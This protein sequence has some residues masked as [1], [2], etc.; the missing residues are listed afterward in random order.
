MFRLFTIYWAEPHPER[1]AELDLVLK[2]NLSM[3]Q[4]VTILSQ[5]VARPDWFP[6]HPWHQWF[7]GSERQQFQ[8]LIAIAAKTIDIGAEFRQEVFGGDKTVGNIY[9]IANSDIIFT[10]DALVKVADNLKCDEAYCLSR[11]DMYR[12]GGINLFDERSSQDVWVFRGPPKPDIGGAFRVGDPGADNRIAHEFDA[13]GYRVL[14][15]SKSI[16]CVHYHLATNK[17]GSTRRT[18]N[19]AANRVPLPYLMVKPHALGEEPEYHRPTRI[20]KRAGFHRV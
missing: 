9:V 15:P 16:Q 10:H 8:D 19:I 11:W 13:A 18:A 3:F 12:D 5:N 1:R 17:D 2:I 6:N 4:E 14:N 7:E 20:S